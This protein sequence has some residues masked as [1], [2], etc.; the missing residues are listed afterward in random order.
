MNTAAIYV[1]EAKYEFLK[2]LRVP[3]FSLSTIGFPL[4]FYVLFGL[5][6]NSAA[7]GMSTYLLATYGAFGVIGVC[8]YGFGVGLA[9]ERGLG[10]LELKQASP[11][12][13]AAYFIAKLAM[14]A[15]FSIIV[16]ALLFTLGFTLGHVR[17][18]PFDTLRLA[19]ILIAGAIPFGAMGLAFGYFVKPNAAPALTNLIYLPMAFCSGLWIPLQFLPTPLQHFAPFLPAYHL[20]RLALGVLGLD[21]PNAYWGHWAALA[22]FTMIFLGLA[23]LGYMRDETQRNG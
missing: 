16:I 9:N 8:L 17:L 13:P 14:S 4:M 15:L 7:T 19:A 21:Q 18:A 2:L 10:W 6:M 23:R 20:S 22:A 5:V 12:P 11:L 1:K 3:A